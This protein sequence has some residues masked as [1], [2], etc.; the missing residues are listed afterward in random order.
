MGR[1]FITP[2]QL[3]SSMSGADAP[4]TFDVRRRE[5]FDTDDH[6][7]PGA[8]WRS[9]ERITEMPA[10]LVSDRTVVVY[11]MH[12]LQVSQSAAAILR[13]RGVDA[14]VL[15]GG[16]DAWKAARLP[17]L[18]RSGLPGLF[19]ETASRWV[20]RRRPKIDRL[21]CPWLIRRF[22]DPEAEILFVEPAQVVV[23]ARE[24]DAL[25]FDIE[26]AEITHAG[27]LCSF[28]ALLERSGID[29]PALHEL[30]LIIRGAD[31]ARLDLAPEAAGL[32]AVSIGISALAGEDDHL[33]LERGTTLY[34]ALYA[35]RRK[36]PGETH[37]W[38]S[39]PRS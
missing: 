4:R 35:W 15:R 38:P 19:R 7:I 39:G 37:D 10:G 5:A 22:I 3:W 36:A 6:V 17:T 18:R 24:L 30:A 14:R 29:D 9:H 21:A 20:T 1:Y 27:D 13:S 34:D 8:L 2:E 26:G 16:I 23:V 28:D 31:T 11:C 25:A 12:G 32:L 33:A